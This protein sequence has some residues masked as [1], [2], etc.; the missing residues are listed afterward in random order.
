MKDTPVR[1]AKVAR[2]AF[3]AAGLSVTEWAQARGFRRE[4]V[5]AVLAGRTKG[6]RGESH[7]IAVALGIKPGPTS[8]ATRLQLGQEDL[9][10]DLAHQWQIKQKPRL[11]GRG[12]SLT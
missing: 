2:E 8:A 6:R 4:H 11:A 5:Y 10:E 7:R 9:H 1:S 3:E 12:F